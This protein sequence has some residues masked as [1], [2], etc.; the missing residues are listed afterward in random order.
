MD[1]CCYYFAFKRMSCFFN[2]LILNPKQNSSCFQCTWLVVAR[3]CSMRLSLSLL[4]FLNAFL[5]DTTSGQQSLI[6]IICCFLFDIVCCRH[7]TG[8]SMSPKLHRVQ[9]PLMSRA[10]CDR[11]FRS[12]GYAINVDGTIVCAG[13]LEGG[14]DA[15]QVCRKQSPV[16]TVRCDV[17]VVTVPRDPSSYSSTG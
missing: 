1:A 15:C 2:K 10:E 11:R 7:P 6:G 17:T 16:C 14:K 4:S 13:W 12:A 8:V 5:D 9:V 3:R